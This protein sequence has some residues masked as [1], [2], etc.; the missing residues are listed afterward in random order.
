METLIPRSGEVRALT[1]LGVVSRRTVLKGG[2]GLAAGAALAT[3][4]GVPPAQAGL[5]K[6]AK[7][8]ARLVCRFT[9]ADLTGQWAAH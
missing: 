2:V 4:V 5:N 1:E 7:A 9:G 6:L 3:T 8:N